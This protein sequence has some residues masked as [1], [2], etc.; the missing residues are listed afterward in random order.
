LT[1]IIGRTYTAGL[2][3][4]K[5]WALLA[6][7]GGATGIGFA[8]IL[9]RWSE[10]GPSATAFY[11]ILFALPLLWGWE[12][13]AWR[14]GVPPRLPSRKTEL[15][16]LALAGLFFTGDLAVWH[17]SLRLT[18]VANSTLLT[19]FAPF[20]V[21]LGARF[22]FRERIRPVFLAGMALALGGA[23]LV[24]GA[25]FEPRH[26]IGDLLGLATAVFYAAYQMTVK[27]LRRSLATTTIMAW[28]GLVSCPALLLVAVASGETLV[29]P[30]LS[31]WLALVALAVVSHVGG[32]TLIAGAFG[33]LPVAFA[34]L[35]LL[36]QPVIAALLAW[37]ALHE[38]LTWPQAV[39]GVI[40]LTGI[41]LARRGNAER[42]PE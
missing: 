12:A 28:S 31:G 7:L 21:M 24:I 39:G 33:H 30:H 32:Q 34:S 27:E 8:P 37:A 41:A 4:T 17:W 29:G 6:L 9:V 13:V 3:N 15:I 23:A 25:R 2:L 19:N 10:V 16:L 22:W 14:K 26:F 42:A 18:S 20:F 36:L 38:S 5:Q 40:V 11:R 35:G 1:A